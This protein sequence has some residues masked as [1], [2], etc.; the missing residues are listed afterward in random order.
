M[1]LRAEQPR[2]P[3]AFDRLISE[4]G[5]TVPD[6][7]DVLDYLLEHAS[8]G[9]VLQ[10]A[11]TELPRYF[12]SNADR[13]LH[14]FHDQEWGDIGPLFVTIEEPHDPDSMPRNACLLS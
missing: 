4:Y 9:P 7:Q 2:L 6:T 14:V 11:V 13:M 5:Y 3:D 12:P 10:E 8:V 1:A